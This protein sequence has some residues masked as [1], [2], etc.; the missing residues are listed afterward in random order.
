MK[1][2]K[3]PLP[4]NELSPG[5]SFDCWRNNVPSRV[6]LKN[7]K[8]PLGA[9]AVPLSSALVPE[10]KQTTAVQKEANIQRLSCIIKT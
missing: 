1:V 5:S 2:P 6:P 8:K 7:A 3:Q 9:R 10:L 4:P